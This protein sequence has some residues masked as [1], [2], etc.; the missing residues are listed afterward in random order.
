M[1]DKKMPLCIKLDKDIREKFKNMTHERKSTM[2]NTL[3][4]FVSYYI[5]NP[6]QFSVR[7][8]TSIVINGENTNGS[9]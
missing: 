4:A 7:N 2:Q 6:D 5:T 1:S 8:N 3:N 9:I